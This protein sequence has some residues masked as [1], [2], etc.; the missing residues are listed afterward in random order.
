M[1]GTTI[2]PPAITVTPDPS[3]KSEAASSAEVGEMTSVAFVIENPSSVVRQVRGES[4]PTG[5]G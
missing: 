1:S 2:V 5:V 3:P 4:I